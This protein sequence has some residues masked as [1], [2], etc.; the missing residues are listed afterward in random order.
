MVSIAGGSCGGREGER[1]TQEYCGRGGDVFGRGKSLPGHDWSL[2]AEAD[3]QA[4]EHL[5]A[6]PDSARRCRAEGVDH[7]A[8]DCCQGGSEDD[9]GGEVAEARDADAGGNDR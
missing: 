1:R 9:E 6:D 2:E 3:A 4:G 8:A 7:T 5:V